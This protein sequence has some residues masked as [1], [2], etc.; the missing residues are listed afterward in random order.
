MNILSNIS[1]KLLPSQPRRIVNLEKKKTYVQ[2]VWD[3]VGDFRPDHIAEYIRHRDVG[4][5]IRLDDVARD[6]RRHDNHEVSTSI[7][8]IAMFSYCFLLAVRG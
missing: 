2:N 6:M 1:P 4:E 3:D 5:N 8:S 7:A